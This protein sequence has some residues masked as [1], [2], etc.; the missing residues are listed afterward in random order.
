MNYITNENQVIY[1]MK[2]LEPTFKKTSYATI[3]KISY[4]FFILNSI[5]ECKV[6]FD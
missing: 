3:G 1:P 2:A 5:E 4:L 6:E